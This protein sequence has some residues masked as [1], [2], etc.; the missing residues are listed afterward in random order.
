MLTIAGLVLMQGVMAGHG[1]TVSDAWVREAP[2]K[3]TVLAGF[4]VIN[5]HSGKKRSLVKASAS[6]FGKAGLHRTVHED[7]MAKMVHQEKI[8]IPANGSVVFKP[9]DYHIML[10]KPKKSYKAGD[11]IKIILGFDDG[12]EITVKYTVRKD[13]GIKDDGHMMDQNNHDMGRMEH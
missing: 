11:H 12:S 1:I 13:M 3:A 7:G 10:M 2:P 5:N 9:G 4:M 6:G 8:D